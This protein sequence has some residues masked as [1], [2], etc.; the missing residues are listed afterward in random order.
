MNEEEFVAFV[1]ASGG[2]LETVAR[3]LNGGDAAAA[4]DLVQGVLERSWF[5]WQKTVPD[6]PY[7]YARSALVKAH[8]SER[9]RARWRLEAVGLGTEGAGDPGPPGGDEE[10]RTTDR[11][12]LEE[13]LRLLPTRQRQA[14]VLRFLEDLPVAE[15]ASLLRCSTGAVKR[16]THEGLDKLSDALREQWGAPSP[17]PRSSIQSEGQPG[18]RSGQQ[19]G[20]GQTRPERASK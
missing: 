5:A 14:V 15:V 19:A 16:N 12:V 11:L 3:A 1:R 10:L 9:R 6:H 2:R 17:L 7:A 8:I 4:E 20:M 13:A 18:I